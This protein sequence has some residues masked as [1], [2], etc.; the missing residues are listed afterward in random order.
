MDAEV[1]V[2][3][4]KDAFPGAQSNLRFTRSY[5]VELAATVEEGTEIKSLLVDSIRIPISSISLDGDILNNT[6]FQLNGRFE[7]ILISARQYFYDSD[8][9][10]DILE[11][12]EYE[13]S[14]Q[15]V[16]E[17]EAWIELDCMG[18]TSYFKLGLLEKLKSDYHP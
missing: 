16:P 4:I 11:E 14:G 2:K 13:L 15:S 8:F 5:R 12:I 3:T 9:E 10:P 6:A 7:S 17:K 18:T 1:K